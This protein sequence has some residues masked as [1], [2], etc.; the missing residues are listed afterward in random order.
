MQ[1]GKLR[2]ENKTILAPLGGMLGLSLRM[3]YRDLGAAM[4]C[5]G[6]IDA[7]K[8][9]ESKDGRMIN[10]LYKEEVVS[11]EERPVCIQLIGSDTLCMAEAARRAENLASVIDLNF[12][13]PLRRSIDEGCGAVLLRNPEHIA[14]IVE[15]VVG[16]V[17]V[18][19]TAKIRIGI[20]GND[21]DIVR[22]A[23]SIEGAGA[24]AITVHGRSADE[25]YA[26]PVHWEYIKKVKDSVRIPVVGN[27]GV[28]SASDAKAMLEKTGCD[29]VM[30]GT[31]AIIN[32]GIFHQ[33][34]E[35][36]RTGEA[37]QV[38]DMTGLLK[39]FKRYFVFARKV[40]G[41]GLYVFLKCSCR[42][43]LKMRTYMI[44]S[45]AGTNK[46]E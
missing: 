39:F 3:T 35:L 46:L 8:V 2:L 31:W 5:V 20:K 29:F 10:I 37:C 40:E 23:K 25:Y 24:S 7:K 14:R 36:L 11:E 30:I 19:V 33:I 12:S 15:A 26:G 1:I 38:S 4:T 22:V 13:S 9:A 17:K 44:G 43:F 27:G 34:D 42:N 6:V 32:P 18:P 45:Q 21:I 16:S 28:N 41:K